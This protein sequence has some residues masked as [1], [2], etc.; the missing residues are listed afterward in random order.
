MFIVG[1]FVR[2]CVIFYMIKV[3]KFLFVAMVEHGY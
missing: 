1:V 2:V 3:I